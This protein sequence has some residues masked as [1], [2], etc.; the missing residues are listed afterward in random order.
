MINNRF[1]G[2]VIGA[3]CLMQLLTAGSNPVSANTVTDRVAIDSLNPNE[4]L[5]GIFYG[6]LK[7]ITTEAQFRDIKAAHV[8]YIQYIGDADRPGQE[9]IQRN[10]EILDL[11]HR[12]GLYYYPSD[13]RVRGTAA[14]VVAMVNDYKDHPAT[15]GFVIQDEPGP[16]ALDWPADTYKKIL[17]LAPGKVPYVNL[18]PDWAVPNY[19]KGYVEKWVEKAGPENL[20]YLSFD[21]YPLRADG[22]FGGT[23]FNNL[24][25]IR[26]AGLKYGVKTSCYLQSMGILGAYRRPT[27]AELRYSA[28]SALSYGIKN[29][30]WFTYCTPVNQPVE[31]FTSAIIDS[32]GLKT[33]LYE[34]FQQLNKDLKQLG[35]TLIK[36][37][38]TEVYHSGSQEGTGILRLPENFFLQPQDTTQD[39]IVSHMVNR[40][41]GKDY[42]M[43]VNKSFTKTAAVNFR[44]SKPAKKILQ[45]AVTGKMQP[46]DYKRKKGSFSASFLPGEGKLFLL[47]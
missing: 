19:E 40:D 20:Q 38:A 21:N 24:E 4:L 46:T 13:K 35:V 11:S 39:L 44:I 8:D 1:A 43:V 30:V 45:V 15:A 42:V 2:K 16:E 3:W 18:L 37:D 28:Y 41:N 27:V 17:A 12:A 5:I 29:A 31:K 34:P 33:D 25:I 26:R 36:L 6:P 23:Y 14:E 7:S 10:R 9:G 47:E 22:S 32:T